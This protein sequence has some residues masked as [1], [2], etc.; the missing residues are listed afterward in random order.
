[1]EDDGLILTSHDL[2]HQSQKVPET[3]IEPKHPGLIR[4]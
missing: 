3:L 1:M 4:L 2:F